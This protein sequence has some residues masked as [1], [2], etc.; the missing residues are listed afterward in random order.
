MASTTNANACSSSW[1][2]RHQLLHVNR[3]DEA[4]GGAAEERPGGDRRRRLRGVEPIPEE[5]AAP[6]L[7]RGDRA[8]AQARAEVPAA[9]ARVVERREVCEERSIII[10]MGERIETNIPRF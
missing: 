1:P 2:R 10:I 8:V 6:V 3:A 7:A 4:P 9:A 5:V